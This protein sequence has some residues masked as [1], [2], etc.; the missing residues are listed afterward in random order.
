M[1]VTEIQEIRRS[2]KS[3]LAVLLSYSFILWG[4]SDLWV[5]FQKQLRNPSS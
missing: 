4:F 5:G 3:E 1:K 2:S